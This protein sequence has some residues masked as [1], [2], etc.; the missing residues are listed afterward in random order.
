M[1][2]PIPDSAIRAWPV[3]AQDADLFAVCIRAMDDAYLRH[4]AKPVEAEKPALTPDLF[5]QMAERRR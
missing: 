2:A 1:G 4:H 5:K 3:D